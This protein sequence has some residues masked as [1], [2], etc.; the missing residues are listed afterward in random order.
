MGWF[1]YIIQNELGR[2]YTGITTDPQRRLTEHNGSP[3]GAKATRAGRPWR[4]VY[5]QTAVTRSGASQRE[6]EIK[7]MTR[8]KK[9]GLIQTH[10]EVEEIRL[11]QIELGHVL[12]SLEPH[13]VG[14]PTRYRES[15]TGQS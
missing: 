15:E 9:L 5:L 11:N 1:T 7:M 2:L 13:Q 10:G 8:A 4:F 12:S 3:R 14:S 6:Y